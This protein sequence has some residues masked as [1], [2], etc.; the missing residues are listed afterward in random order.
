M[1]LLEKMPI[2]CKL[3]YKTIFK[4]NMHCL[5]IVYGGI[6]GQV[7]ERIASVIIN[8]LI[9]VTRRKEADIVVINHL[10][11]ESPLHSFM[12]AKLGFWCRGYLPKTE[13]HWTM[14]VNDDMEQFYALRSKKHRKHLKQYQNK[15]ERDFSGKIEFEVYT[16]INEVEKAVKEAS[17]ISQK[18]YQ[19]AMGSGF[20][21]QMQRQ[22]LLKT[23]AKKDWL[24]AYILKL[25]GKSAAFRFGLKYGNT[26][27][28][29]V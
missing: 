29:N 25:N 6:L 11:E 10:E 16:G 15:L 22:K 2:K 24:L 23:A 1:V 5:N 17:E 8:E 9:E 12:K 7:D 20:S 27:F 3:G 18:T 26:F 19:Y 21:N 28:C 4:P 14:T 13:T